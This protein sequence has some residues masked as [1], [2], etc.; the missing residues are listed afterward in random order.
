CPWRAPSCPSRCRR[1]QRPEPSSRPRRVQ[2]RRRLSQS[3][4]SWAGALLCRTIVANETP[5]ARGCEK[6]C[7]PGW[8]KRG[9]GLRQELLGD[10][11]DVA[12]LDL[13]LV[14]LHHVAAQAAGLLGVRDAETPDGLGDEGAQRRLVHSLG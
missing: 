14:G 7:T 2:T 5:A 12:G 10:A 9:L 3:S 4:S 1:P 13:P 8:W 11:F 6:C